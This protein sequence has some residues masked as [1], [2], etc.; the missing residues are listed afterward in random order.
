M[1]AQS[2]ARPSGGRF[3]TGPVVRTVVCL[4]VCLVALPA[5]Q[6][7]VTIRLEPDQP[8]PYSPLQQIAVDVWIDNSS[9]FDLPLLGVQLDFSDTSTGVLLPATLTWLL[10]PPSDGDPNLP[11]P[12]WEQPFAPQ[13]SV[14]AEGSLRVATLTIQ[15]PRTSGCARLD[16]MNRLESNAAL[17][18][19]VIYDNGPGT[20]TLRAYWWNLTG[21]GLGVPVNFTPDT[22]V[23][24]GQDDDC[25][26]L[27]DEGFTVSVYDPF[28]HDYVDMG[29]GGPCISGIGE[30]EVD[31]ILECRADGTGL[32]CVPLTTPP[33]PGVEGPYVNGTCYDYLDN[34][35]DGLIDFDDPD[36]HGAELCDGQDNDGD[37]L[38]D[39][40]WDL[41]GT[42]CIVGYGACQKEGIWI[43]RQDGEG[44]ECSVQPLTTINEWEG[45]P[46]HPH[47][48]DGLDNDCDGRVDLDDPDCQQPEICD[49]LDNNGDGRVDEE[50]ADILGSPCVVGVGACERHGVWVCTADGSGVICSVSPGGPTPEGPGCDCG[51]A[52]DNDCDGLTDLNDPDCGAS[53]FRARAALPTICQPDGDCRSW[54]LIEYDALNGGP[55]TTT[56]AEILALDVDGTL[57]GTLPVNAGETLRLRSRT[58]A[59]DLFLGTTNTV[60]DAGLLNNWALRMTGPEIQFSPYQPESG[61]FDT[62]CDDDADMADVI[63]LQTL[64]GNVLAYH[65]VIAPVPMLRVL[66]NNGVGQATAYASIVPHVEMWS[67]NETVIAVGESDRLQVDVALVNILPAINITLDGV[68][69]ADALG[70]DPETHFPGGPYG[71]F[72]TLPNGCT[73]HICELV[74]DTADR[75]TL[76]ARSMRMVIE[77]MCC[78]GHRLVVTADLDPAS[79]ID[80]WPSDCAIGALEQNEVAYGF[81]VDI[82]TPTDGQQVLSSN[83]T[84]IGEICHGLPLEE[85]PTDPSIV[86]LN[87]LDVATAN[88]TITPGDGTTTA[89]R[90]RYYFNTTLP[91]TNLFNDFLGNGVPGTVDPGS[92]GIVAEG[93]DLLANGAYDRVRFAF[94]EINDSAR[95][96]DAN[97]RGTAA[98]GVTLATTDAALD[99]IAT[100]VLMD[101]APA[102]IQEL[103]NMLE[104]VQGK[105]FSF[106]TDVCNIVLTIFPVAW[107]LNTPSYTVY[108]PDINNFVVDV[109]PSDNQ[110]YLKVTVPQASINGS[111]SGSCEIEG[112][113]GECA[114]R[115]VAIVNLDVQVDQAV[116]D[117]TITEEDLLT[118][119]AATPVL[120]INSSDVHI[121][122]VDVGSDVQCWAGELLNILSFGLLESAVD[123]IVRDLVEQYIDTI[124]IQ[125]YLGL[126]EIEPI[127]LDYFKLRPINLG[128][129]N[130]QLD[131]ALSDVQITPAGLAASLSTTFTP[132]VI[133]PEIQ[134]Q[135]GVP[136]TP[137]PMPLPPLSSPALGATLL[138]SDDAV[139][140][141]LYALS[142]TGLFATEYE[143]Q[144]QL[145]NL[146]PSNCATL[147]DDRAIGFCVAINGQ[148][149]S[150]APPGTGQ[151]ACE[152][153]AKLLDELNLD[154]TTPILLH[155]RLDIA[156]TFYA[157]RS[158]GV[159]SI[160]AYLR[161]TE[162]YVGVLA[163]RDG[164]G[165]VSDDYGSY[166]SCF[167]NPATDTPCVLFGGCFDVNFAVQMTL[168]TPGNIPQLDFEVVNVQLSNATG[169]EGGTITPGDLSGLEDIFAGMVFALIEQ[170]VNGNLP[171]LRLEGLDFD[172]VVYLPN[173][174]VL[175]YGN[176]YDLIFED[177][178]GITADPN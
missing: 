174:Q 171:T 169:C 36:C 122:V 39:E 16:V 98:V 14:P 45:P 162:V 88:P 112:L 10:T 114:I 165:L 163:D 25:D 172:G 142:R 101:T 117:M 68:D 79:M 93:R 113:F 66:A 40:E 3:S 152:S 105:Q 75:E 141:M 44:I 59:G 127:T 110:V 77:G 78:G 49:Y 82:F 60:V 130:V 107:P 170:H 158:Q 131:L 87:G 51:D 63:A 55:N 92:T 118:G 21:G 52:I 109:I 108:P 85:V 12:Y 154:P 90:Y 139:N 67:P 116:L 29:W 47:C 26:G 35:C 11:V 18:A 102:L 74:V 42:P 5:V 91:R 166:P 80:P 33:D 84:V 99:T 24:N 22:E 140:E 100:N 145:D 176:Q 173:L 94:G 43:C 120:T 133:D 1:N 48:F 126:I 32:E 150:T 4:G 69:V 34:D 178:F 23:C 41:L 149:C 103:T 83:V 125:E 96:P 8:G 111:V 147:P 62:D 27:I 115:V 146:T 168:S 151:L 143:D 15:A 20:T 167:G 137:A 31:G 19:E 28:T 106:A 129:M 76:S 144:R 160:I 38:I 153:A 86:W 164:D 6:A 72:V 89:D 17:G 73:A 13:N 155:G 58:A 57:L 161:L 64:G 46:G 157:F 7:A 70:L 175:T 123:S 37:G 71:G 134:L 124:D 119:A 95:S 136:S 148:P 135:P 61:L 104:S 56:T 53:V 159:D 138:V 121:S 50:W 54:H 30:C 128:T 65:E 132:T 2:A 177:F 81:A 156:P 9:A 97:E